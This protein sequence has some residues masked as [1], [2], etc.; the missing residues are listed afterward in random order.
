MRKSV[1]IAAGVAG[2]VAMIAFG[3]SCS[4]ATGLFLPTYTATLIAANEPNNAS[5]ATGT[6]TATLVDHGT[7]FEYEVAVTG[8]T[9]ISA[10]HIHGPAAAGVNAAIVE[11][12]FI[13]N[14][15]PFGQ[16]DG[17]LATGVITNATNASLTIDAL[18]AMIIAGNA[19]VNVHTNPGFPA[20]AIRG[21]LV[22]SN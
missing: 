9:A 21:Q 7:F 22:R 14:G 15:P 10:A 20:G 6:G 3:I 18:R 19:Y 4:D 16:V 8:L 5:T 1:R 11:N 2:A 13:P 12:L 17:V